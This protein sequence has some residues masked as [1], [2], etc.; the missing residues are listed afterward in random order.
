MLHARIRMAYLDETE[1]GISGEV[2]EPGV[3][4]SES[5][6]HVHLDLLLL[7]VHPGQALQVEVKVHIGGHVLLLVGMG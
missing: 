3:L 5:K 1:S 4:P 2:V 6:H 7:G